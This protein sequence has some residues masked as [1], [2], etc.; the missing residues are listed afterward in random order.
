M[1]DF[2]AVAEDGQT[3]TLGDIRQ[4][5]VGRLAAGRGI[6]GNGDSPF[7][8]LQ[9]FVS[10][11]LPALNDAVREH[12]LLNVLFLGAGGVLSL[13]FCLFA[14]MRNNDEDFRFESDGVGMGSHMSRAS[15][16]G[17]VRSMAS[18]VGMQTSTR[19]GASG[20]AS[21]SQAERRVAAT[22][23]VNLCGMSPHYPVRDEPQEAMHFYRDWS[24]GIMDVF[25][26]IPQCGC[27][28]FCGLC[29]WPWRINVTVGSIGT[30]HGVCCKMT[31]DDN[32]M[33][34]VWCALLYYIGF[35][36]FA[37][38]LYCSHG[39]QF[40][41]MDNVCRTHQIDL[42]GTFFDTYIEHLDIS[43]ALMLMLP[44]V[45]R[46]VIMQKGIA[47]RF[48]IQEHDIVAYLKVILLL[49]FASMQSGRHVDTYYKEHTVKRTPDT[50]KLPIIGRPIVIRPGP[51]LEE[52]LEDE[53][54]A[55]EAK[56]K[57]PTAA[58]TAEDSS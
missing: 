3:P 14:N 35:Y 18:G 10:L 12:G 37:H 8:P 19:S 33:T 15:S 58:A 27:A 4:P 40:V 46:Q 13:A 42:P 41:N 52:P 1:P 50:P 57:S 55:A 34:S 39:R 11:N 17:S 7:K 28:F 2:T 30:V 54:L 21:I 22:I 49:P 29:F 9:D 25:H 16:R 47:T 44:M 45:W 51:V 36:F 32:W 24:S 38:K 5:Q 43:V 56:L 31:K 6:N 23:K 48:R 26:D 53:D 20:A